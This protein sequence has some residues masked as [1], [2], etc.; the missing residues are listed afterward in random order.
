[1]S[2]PIW[3]IL[4]D[5]FIILIW[6]HA[7]GINDFLYIFL[8]TK[9][10]LTDIGVMM[11]RDTSFTDI[12]LTPKVNAPVVI[13]AQQQIM[14]TAIVPCGYPVPDIPVPVTF[15]LTPIV[16]PS[17][18]MY[19]QPQGASLIITHNLETTHFNLDPEHHLQRG[20]IHHIAVKRSVKS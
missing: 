9:Q 13:V 1:M 17:R 15:V 16:P 2:L 18:K 3:K 12:R 11:S 14:E 8:Q 20:A 7:H 19:F 10:R 5:I 4:F 6:S